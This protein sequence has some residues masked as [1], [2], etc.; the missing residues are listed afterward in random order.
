VKFGD[1]D[2]RPCDD[3]LLLH[4]I[5]EDLHGL[6]Q[7]SCVSATDYRSVYRFAIFNVHLRDVLDIRAVR[8]PRIRRSGELLEGLKQDI[9]KQRYRLVNLR[10]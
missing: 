6:D 7:F 3:H 2:T 9:L 10:G 1:G 8:S 4:R 5:F